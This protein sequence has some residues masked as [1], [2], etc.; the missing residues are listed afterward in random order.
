MNP[1]IQWSFIY[2][3][4]CSLLLFLL[5]LVYFYSLWQPNA[6]SVD[7]DERR[8][9]QETIHST[10]RASRIPK[11]VFI[12]YYIVMTIV[13]DRLTSC[14]CRWIGQNINLFKLSNFIIQFHPT[15]CIPIVSEWPISYFVRCPHF[16]KLVAISGWW[17]CTKFSGSLIFYSFLFLFSLL[18]VSKN[19]MIFLIKMKLGKKILSFYSFLS[20]STSNGVNLLNTGHSKR[21]AKWQVF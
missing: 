20:L 5:L 21:R 8:N 12:I 16:K 1:S 9:P 2:G 4:I 7:K 6:S 17:H 3:L 19:K 18:L 10:K 13:N 14:R 15:S 11:W